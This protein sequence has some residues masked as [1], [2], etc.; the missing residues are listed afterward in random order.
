MKHIQVYYEIEMFKII[1]TFE[2]TLT[3]LCNKIAELLQLY[4]DTEYHIVCSF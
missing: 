4:I 1:C 3:V 2:I